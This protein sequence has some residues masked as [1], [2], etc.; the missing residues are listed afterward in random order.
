MDEPAENLTPEEVNCLNAV[1]AD[2]YTL[3]GSPS[4]VQPNP[5]PALRDDLRG[6][7]DARD[8]GDFAKAL[9]LLRK[10]E[11]FLDPA[12]VAYLRG[13]IWSEAGENEIAVDF[14]QRAKDL[15]P[16]NGNYASM[17]LDAF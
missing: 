10:N 8:A 2:F 6:A 11:A 7:L 16:Q 14:F 12:G 3:S 5:P 9:E 15:A 17:W 13:S 1:S 4:H